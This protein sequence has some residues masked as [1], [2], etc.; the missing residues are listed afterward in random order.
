MMILLPSGRGDSPRFTQ[1]CSRL[2]RER[3]VVA[4]APAPSPTVRR[5]VVYEQKTPYST[6]QYHEQ[7][8]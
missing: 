7:A 3:G 4:L 6:W 8:V 5:G 2:V 1:D